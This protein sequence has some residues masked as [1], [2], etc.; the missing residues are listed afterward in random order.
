MPL[1]SVMVAFML[2]GVVAVQFA[3]VKLM[4]GTSAKEFAANTSAANSIPKLL[5]VFITGGDGLE[6]KSI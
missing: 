1:L 2:I 6:G 3:G 4:L 5:N